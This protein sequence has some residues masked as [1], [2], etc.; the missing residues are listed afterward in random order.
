[1]N[2]FARTAILCYSACLIILVVLHNPFLGY[3]NTSTPSYFGDTERFDSSMEGC[4]EEAF[5]VWQ[6]YYK[7]SDFLARLSTEAQFNKQL[8]WRAELER[9]KSRESST[10]RDKAAR[11]Q[12]A[13]VKSTH[14]YIPGEAKSFTVWQSTGA[15]V[16]WAATGLNVILLAGAGTFVFVVAILLF[17]RSPKSDA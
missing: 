2:P 14:Q 17:G 3:D 6:Y 12:K 5:N 10:L 1:M 16:S 15:F 13:C 11:H 8:D 7:R 9:M 4:T